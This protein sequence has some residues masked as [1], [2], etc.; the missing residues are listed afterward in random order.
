MI[1]NTADKLNGI[2]IRVQSAIRNKVA[3]SQSMGTAF[4]VVIAIV[5]GLIVLGAMVYVINTAMS[6]AA[7][8]VD[9]I[10]DAS[11]PTWAPTPTTGG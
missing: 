10:F 4:G 2:I 9:G 8:K 5:V 7:A 6:G 1:S 11:V 3:E